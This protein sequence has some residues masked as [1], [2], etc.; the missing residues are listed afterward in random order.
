[1]IDRVLATGEPVEI[2]HQGKCV[3]LVPEQGRRQ[4][5]CCSRGTRKSV[6][7]LLVSSGKTNQ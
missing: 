5:A 6:V 7:M 3:L 4:V 2:E 1:M